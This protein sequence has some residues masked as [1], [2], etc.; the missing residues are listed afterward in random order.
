MKRLVNGLY[1]FAFVSVLS[2]LST[3][4]MS[5]VSNNTGACFNRMV[6]ELKA[7]PMDTIK[8]YV[9]M[10]DFVKHVHRDRKTKFKGEKEIRDAF[11]SVIHN[12][13]S[14][15]TSIA[16]SRI[17]ATKELVRGGYRTVSYDI[18]NGSDHISCIVVLTPA[19]KCMVA[20]LTVAGVPVDDLVINFLKKQ[21]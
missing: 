9:S 15:F 6:L 14:H 12:L 18:A 2:L 17:T 1:A 11:N 7:N 19:P 10:P 13:Q 8:T 16:T 20:N 21:R 3:S 5:A 4:A